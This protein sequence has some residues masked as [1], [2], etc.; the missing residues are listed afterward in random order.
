MPGS[1]FAVF[2][3]IRRLLANLRAWLEFAPSRNPDAF[4][5]FHAYRC[6]RAGPPTPSKITPNRPEVAAAGQRPDENSL[7]PWDRRSFFVVCQL[8]ADR[9]A[10]RDEKSGGW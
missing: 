6:P 4:P 8:G 2:W 5:H 10:K 3:R 9:P 7:A 1:K